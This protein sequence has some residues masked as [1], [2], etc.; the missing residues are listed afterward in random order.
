MS[1]TSVTNLVDRKQI[2]KTSGRCFNCLHRSHFSHN[3][4]SSSRC[5]KCKKKHHTSICNASVSQPPSSPCSVESGLNPDA[6]LFQLIQITSTLCLDNLQTVFLQT[7]CAVIHHPRDPHVSLKVCLILDGGSQK[8]DISD[9][10]RGLLNLEA[11]GEQ[12]LSIATFGSNKGST[13]VCLVVNV[14]L[15]LRGYPSMSLSV[16]VMPAICEP[17]VRQ[18]VSACLKQYPHL[19]G[20]ELADSL[21]MELSM[22][23]DVLIGTNYYWQLVTGSIELVGLLLYTLN[24]AGCCLVYLPMMSL[25]SVQ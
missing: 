15:C 6:L 7:A 1:C 3:C 4:K 16:Y 23:V 13:R 12:S 18:P 25:I 11:T 5:W 10:A 21:S 17:L 9:H 20:L 19:L 14:G 8:S 22:P 24:W 2:L